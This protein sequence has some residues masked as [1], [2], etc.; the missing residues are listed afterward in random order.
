MGVA[1][2]ERRIRTLTRSRLLPGE[3]IVAV[4]R[5]WVSRA[6]PAHAFALR[7]R[8]VVV[9]TD[10]RL[11]L[12]GVGYWTRRPRRRVLDAR[13]DEVAVHDR[14]RGR[15]RE[16]HVGRAG[17]RR[18]LVLQLGRG[19]AADRVVAAALARPAHSETPVPRA[20]LGG[21]AGA[22]SLGAGNAPAESLEGPQ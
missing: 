21:G 9:V 7:L 8:Q 20:P 13:L 5:A 3:Q 2:D 11:L 12:Y 15:R 17:E 18:P 10:R 22:L 6:G 14:S 4:G 16:L 19:A 1:A